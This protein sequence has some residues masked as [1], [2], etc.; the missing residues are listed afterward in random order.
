MAMIAMTAFFLQRLASEPPAKKTPTIVTNSTDE[1]AELAPRKSEVEWQGS[2]TQPK[3]ISL[4]TIHAQGYLQ[5]VGIDQH[6]AIAVPNNIHMAGWYVDSQPP[7]EKG[8]SIIAGH[9]DGRK[10]DGIFKDLDKLQSNDEFR[11][12]FGDDSTKTFVVQEVVRVPAA[13]AASTLFSQEPSIIGQLNLITCGG[14]FDQKTR[15]YQDRVIVIAKR[16]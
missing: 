16:Q 2:A 11:V 14:T 15:S 7:G 4:P 12:T 1:P 3:Y 10:M 8:L 6:K 13:E 9:V 5:W